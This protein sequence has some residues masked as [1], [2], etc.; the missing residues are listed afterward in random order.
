MRPLNF[1]IIFEGRNTLIYFGNHPSLL[2]S[3]AP[4]GCT[5]TLATSNFFSFSLSCTPNHLPQYS[6]THSLSLTLSLF[7]SGSTASSQTL[8]LLAVCFYHF[9]VKSKHQDDD[10]EDVRKSN[11]SFPD[12]ASIFSRSREINS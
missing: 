1:I 6:L 9:A 5:R 3:P 12:F 4:F 8:F 2:K 11:S 7:L 10:D